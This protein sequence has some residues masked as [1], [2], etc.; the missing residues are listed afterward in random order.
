MAYIQR[1]PRRGQ[2]YHCSRV[3]VVLGN[4]STIFIANVPQSQVG[5]ISHLDY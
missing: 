1:I 5:L 2:V 3:N 4:I